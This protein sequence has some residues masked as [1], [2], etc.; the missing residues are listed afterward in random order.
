MQ[1]VRALIGKDDLVLFIIQESK[2]RQYLYISSVDL[3]E[4]L[5]ESL[6]EIIYRKSS[7]IDPP[8]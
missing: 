5:S 2:E 1:P 3:V 4:I 8:V 7:L 6:F